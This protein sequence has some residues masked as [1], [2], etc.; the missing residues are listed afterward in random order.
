[1][2]TVSDCG[3][4]VRELVLAFLTW[5]RATLC[6]WR[7]E[8]GVGCQVQLQYGAPHVGALLEAPGWGGRQQEAV[9]M[10]GCRVSL[11]ALMLQKLGGAAVRLQDVSKQELGTQVTWMHGFTGRGEWSPFVPAT[12]SCSF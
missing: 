7:C 3:F 10:N 12:R 9:A 11:L 8:V 4:G 2:V 6:A 1:M 5:V